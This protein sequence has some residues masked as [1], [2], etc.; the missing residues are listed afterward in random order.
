MNTKIAKR[1]ASFILCC[2]C[3][4]LSVCLQKDDRTVFLNLVIGNTCCDTKFCLLRVQL[5]N[6][7]AD[8]TCM[9]ICTQLL[10]GQMTSKFYKM[11]ESK[12]TSCFVYCCI[13]RTKPI[14]NEMLN[15]K[16]ALWFKKKLGNCC[17]LQ[18]PLKAS[19]CKRALKTL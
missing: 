1:L 14:A 18:S 16:G 8:V 9:L 4:I 7:S 15:E 11:C 6:T 17:I 19:L 13:S 12:E 10:P 5:L 2:V 3:Y